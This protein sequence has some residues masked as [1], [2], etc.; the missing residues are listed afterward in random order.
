[1][2]RPDY[3]LAANAGHNQKKDRYGPVFFQLCS[4]RARKSFNRLQCY[5]R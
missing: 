2:T 4:R 1:M 5:L 3:Y